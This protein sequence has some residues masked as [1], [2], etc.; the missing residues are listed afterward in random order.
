M[1]KPI[2]PNLE[3]RVA[4]I[5]VRMEGEGEMPVMRGH[6]AVVNAWSAD[7][8][9]F[10][11]MITSGA[12]SE[13]LGDDVRA[14]INHDPNMVM[15]RTKSGTLRM[16]EDGDGLAIENDPPDTSYSR[17]LQV[18]MKRGD[19]DQMS[20]AF[21]IPEGGDSWKRAEDCIWERT[22]TKIKRLFD[23]SYVT[24]PAYPDTSCAVRSLES[25]KSKEVP[26]VSNIY[27]RRLRL[28]LEAAL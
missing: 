24:Y 3:R 28:E 4:P 16:K 23:V 11:E 7:L 27:L 10:R 9:G 1:N 13:C 6:A 14:L 17:D 21:S 5:V 22:I 18:S 20:F 19:L 15:G 12:F 25:V 8:G 26:Q 2:I